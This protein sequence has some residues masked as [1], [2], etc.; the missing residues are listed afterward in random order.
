MS[1]P[2]H[3]TECAICRK[4][5]FRHPCQ[6]KRNAY[7]VCSNPCMR[8]ML[9]K[10]RKGEDN[11]IWRG[12]DVG[13]RGLHSWVKRYR[14]KPKAC[15]SCGEI[16][17][18]DLANISQKYKR[19]LNDWEWLCRKCHMTKDG[20]I[21]MVVWQMRKRSADAK[22]KHVCQVC[23]KVRML[24]KGEAKR[25][26]FC[27]QRCVHIAQS[28]LLEQLTADGD[29]I[30]T[31]PSVNHAAEIIGVNPSAIHAVISGKNKRC[32][33]SIWRYAVGGSDD[34]RSPSSLPSRASRRPH[35]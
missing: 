20:R 22:V 27:S 13:M 16:K 34:H 12:K 18:L 21:E 8:K 3:K 28:R 23:K 10:A 11:P 1:K 29:L 35:G 4:I 25:R 15:E 7:Q 19:D 6:L 26:K 24:A 30:K 5:L 9:S 32:K 31:W 14:K 2:T 33:N 17:R